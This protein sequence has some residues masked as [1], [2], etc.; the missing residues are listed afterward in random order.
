[1][2]YDSKTIDAL[3]VRL[4]SDLAELVERLA[5]NNYDLGPASVSMRDGVMVLNV[6]SNTRS[7]RT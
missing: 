4:S 5:Q 3:Q 2:S 7:T 6:M 1:V